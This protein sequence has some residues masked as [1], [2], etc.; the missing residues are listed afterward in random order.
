MREDGGVFFRALS[1]LFDIETRRCAVEFSAGSRGVSSHAELLFRG[2]FG[3]A[4]RENVCVFERG[5]Q[6]DCVQCPVAP[7][8]LYVGLFAPQACEAKTRGGAG[9]LVKAKAI[10]PFVFSF[11]SETG[12]GYPRP[13]NFGGLELTLFGPALDNAPE[14][15]QSAALGLRNKF[16]ATIH[17][18]GFLAPFQGKEAEDDLSGKSRPLR[19]WIGN[20]DKGGQRETD[21]ENG[22]MAVEFLTPVRMT[23]RGKPVRPQDFTFEKMVKAIVNRLRDLKRASGSDNRMGSLP[24][25][26]FERARAVEIVRN[27]L[28]WATRKRVS[29]R[30]DEEVFS[31][32]LVGD[33]FFSRPVGHFR[34]LLLAGQMV[35]F[36]KG[37]TAGNGR[38]AVHHG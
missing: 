24:D 12:N 2:A 32:G 14:M 19:E 21:S 3:K 7:R 26:F 8:C 1:P 29:I 35:H 20:E 27:S 31:S 25:A 16:G 38:I 23:A 6:N 30:Q 17:R 33:V 5:N 22:A 36:G 9:A 34:K 37:T 4:L 15:V 28:A 13:G 18:A 10:R 11:R